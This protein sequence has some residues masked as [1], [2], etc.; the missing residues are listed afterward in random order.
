MGLDWMGFSG[1]GWGRVEEEWIGCDGLKM[2]E[3]EWNWSRRS[4][5][6]VGLDWM[7]LFVGQ[8]GL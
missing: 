8:I 1:V 3:M 7:G 5:M 2:D 6:G 4:R